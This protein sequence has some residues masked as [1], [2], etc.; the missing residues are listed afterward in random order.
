MQGRQP[1]IQ[2][3]AGDSHLA[4]R[5]IAEFLRRVPPSGP[6]GFEGLV[7]KLLEALT[8]RRYYL[9]R[10]GGQAGCDFS[11]DRSLCS[12]I[13]VECK[14]YGDNTEFDERRL[15]GELMQATR[16]IPDL[17]LWVLAA[18][19]NVSS[20]LETALTGA[21]RELGIG[22]EVISAGDG[23]PSSLEILCAHAQEAVVRYVQ[24]HVSTEEK[25]E[26]V[27]ALNDVA[28]CPCFAE[29]V[30]RMRRSFSAGV[31][32]YD[33]WRTEQNNWL[34][35]Q[36]SSRS[37]SRAAFG[38]LLNIK[39]EGVNLVERSAAWSELDAWL[40]SW[41]KTRAWFCLLGEEG[42]GKTWAT[43]SWLAQKVQTDR[44]FPPTVF[45]PSYAADCN[46]PQAL[47]SATIDRQLGS[48][49][50]KMWERRLKRWMKTPE[51]DAPVL[52]LVLDGINERRRSSWWRYLLDGLAA[53][54]WR[55]RVAVL[56]TC[57]A[58]YWKEYFANLRYLNTRSWT[59]PPYDD[60]ELDDALARHGLTRRDIGGSLMPLI[61]KPRY[62]DLMVKHRVRMDQSG[63]VTPARLV[64][65]DWRD[66][67][68]RKTNVDLSDEVFLD[69]I[70][71]LARRALEKTNCIRESEVEAML[72]SRVDKARTLEELRTGGILRGKGTSYVADERMLAL[73]FGLLLADK[74]EKAVG[75]RGQDPGEAI[76]HWLEPQADM[77]IKASI[78]GNAVLHAL[79]TPEYPPDA[80]VALLRA[81]IGSHNP[82][83]EV[84]ES[85]PAYFPLHPESYFKLAE[86]VWSDSGDNPWGQE[87][88]MRTL[89]R[90]GGIPRFRSK[91]KDVF[92]HW[93]SLVHPHG[94]PSQRDTR[95]ESIS[96]TS[97]RIADRVGS[98]IELGEFTFAGYSL[99]GV[100]DDG[101]LRLGR[102]ALAVVSHLPRRPFLHAIVTGCVAEAVMDYPDKHSLFSWIFASAGESLWTEVEREVQGLLAYDHIATKQA[103]YRLLSFE[104][105]EQAHRLRQ[106]LPREQLFARS[107]LDE[108]HKED[109][110][111]SLLPW[112]QDECEMCA[113]RADLQPSMLVRRL[114]PFC[115]DPH[116]CVP[117]DLGVRIAL[118][119]EAIDRKSIRSGLWVTAEDRALD[120]I[121][122]AL[123]AY[124]PGALAALVLG[125]TH[126]VARREGLALRQLAFHL[127]EHQLILDE[128]ARRR[129]RRAWKQ[130]HCKQGS[131]SDDDRLSEALLF[132]LV[133]Q[134]LDQPEQLR[135]L[136]RRPN[137]TLDLLSF[138]PFFKPVE[139]WDSVRDTLSDPVSLRRVLWMI[140]EH[141]MRIP[142]EVCSTLLAFVDHEDTT[143]RGQVLRILHSTGYAPAIQAI[144]E[145]TWCWNPGHCE[146]ENHWGSLLLSEHASILTY[147]ELCRRVHP[148]HL[149]YVV[150][151]RGSNSAELSQ[152]AEDIDRTW[153]FVGTKVP[154]VP[155]NLPDVEVTGCAK[156]NV[157]DLSRVGLHYSR[158]SGSAR[159]VSR[160]ASWGGVSAV[161]SKDIEE[162][163]SL[164]SDEQDERY[165]G[166][167]E[168]VRETM[169]EQTESG[170]HWFA[171]RFSP[172]ALQEV[173]RDRP[174]LL[175]RWLDP[176]SAE[177]PSAERYLVLMRSFYEALCEAL[178]HCRPSKGVDLYWRLRETPCPV[179]FEDRDT[180]IQLL[181]YILFCAPASDEVLGA[182][183]GRLEKCRTDRELMDIVIMAQAGRGEDW[184]WSLVE[185]G[186][187]SDVP[188]IRARSFALLGL[189]EVDQARAMLDVHRQEQR[190]TW[191]GQV[192]ET[193]MIRL[194]NNDHAKHWFRRFLS[195]IDTVDAWRSFRLF[196]RC[197]DRRFWCWQERIVNEV[198]SHPQMQSRRLFFG[199]NRDRLHNAI[200]ANE[201]ERNESFLGQKV[202]HGEMWPW[203]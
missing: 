104:G 175:S 42:D 183:R 199:E 203:M 167:L 1:R 158:H 122:P 76:A 47:L 184:M 146:E 48:S 36:L 189:V 155:P 29:S 152:Y 180:A 78:C 79:S 137:D 112:T 3:K 60:R 81:W 87:L 22:L 182:W 73:G 16:S 91:L 101:L 33:N 49:C 181:D 114:K 126:E 187:E 176:V 61:R 198:P 153:E 14:R 90:W 127:R 17:D 147:S 111:T 162:F 45:L 110:C 113:R 23:S 195:T 75:L 161:Q 164:W 44:S 20:Q 150:E 185:D 74:T 5:R 144:A 54:P 128:E 190:D 106:A 201:R 51:P 39:E 34:I 145:S 135:H 13:A 41:G 25:D 174:D 157:K 18:S 178:L 12:V 141:P 8:G 26:L 143:V 55:D 118:V 120:E 50:E 134:G 2:W 95:E 173:I 149:G 66:R 11:S 119:A 57:R 139:D 108:R 105:S 132:S 7:A 21:A 10:S 84:E 169:K 38:Q 156:W 35:S 88:M 92:E 166:D 77:D 64:Y 58:I 197:V 80:R 116:L 192:I 131:L 177:H 93:L 59:L 138:Q 151:L 202:L 194:R 133:L 53:E 188:L 125:L 130:L 69:L 100:E 63:D 15:L 67:S 65:E 200:E 129:L 160:D 82:G 94:F 89:L 186:I 196:L 27:R 142:E 52:L 102:A 6:D 168:V 117:E 96:S 171:K 163:L 71:D 148:K 56:I 115:T 193:S 121:E 140:S 103:A 136:L 172:C 165:E 99:F 83:T 179:S 30:E 159:F 24:A 97:Q 107:S 4:T 124:A 37:Q 86:A 32:G 9:A 109:P 72:P 70:R 43:A 31:I 85:L 19:R 123:C 154:D 170:N 191:L 98:E 62:F 28:Q 68:E 40:S 46:T